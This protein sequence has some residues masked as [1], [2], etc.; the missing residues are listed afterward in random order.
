MRQF[1][2]CIVSGQKLKIFKMELLRL[3]YYKDSHH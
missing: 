1:Q 3:T 2:Q